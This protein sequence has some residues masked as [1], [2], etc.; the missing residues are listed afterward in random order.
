MFVLFSFNALG[1]WVYSTF[2]YSLLWMGL[3][4]ALIAEIFVFIHRM[5]GPKWYIPFMVA[6]QII[7][8]IAFMLIS[9]ADISDTRYWIEGV[10]LHVIP[11]GWSIHSTVGSIVVSATIAWVGSIIAFPSKMPQELPVE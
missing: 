6:M 4:L 9:T 7:V 11:F 10:N 2:D 8:L 3:I 5:K 1:V